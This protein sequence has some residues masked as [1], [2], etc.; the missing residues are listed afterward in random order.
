MGRRFQLFVCHGVVQI[1]RGRRAR[2]GISQKKKI[3][4][5]EV[6]ELSFFWVDRLYFTLDDIVC[7]RILASA[8]FNVRSTRPDPKVSFKIVASAVGRR[9]IE[10]K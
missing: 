5:N 10:L 3:N 1:S 6:Q 9:N 4:R 7:T 8:N 2:R